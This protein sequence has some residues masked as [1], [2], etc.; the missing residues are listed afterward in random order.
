MKILNAAEEQTHLFVIIY[1][2][3]KVP[4]RESSSVQHQ[5]VSEPSHTA[6]TV[7]KIIATDKKIIQKDNKFT[8]AV[9]EQQLG[10]S[11]S[12][13]RSQFKHNSLVFPGKKYVS[14]CYRRIILHT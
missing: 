3:I 7:R 4:K 13:T 2:C 1:R 14:F 5:K 11:H 10:Y 9:I 8:Y 12:Y 6:I